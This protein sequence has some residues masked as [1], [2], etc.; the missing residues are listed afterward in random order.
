MRLASPDRLPAANPDADA[1]ADGDARGAGRG[2]VMSLPAHRRERWLFVRT[3]RVWT[4]PNPVILVRWHRSASAKLS[5]GAVA[6]SV[7]TP[8]TWNPLVR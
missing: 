2:A 7:T 8:T 6:N 4:A 1:D 5:R 3:Q